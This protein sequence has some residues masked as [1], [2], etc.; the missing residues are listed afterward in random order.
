M[1]G[2]SGCPTG[3]EI[4]GILISEGFFPHNGHQAKS[5]L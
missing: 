5:R 1:V 2:M 4:F 3:D